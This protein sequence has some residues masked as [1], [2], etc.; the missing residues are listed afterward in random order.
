MHVFVTGGT[1]FIG[2]HSVA[3][4][5]GAGHKVRLFARNGNAVLPAL[6][7]LGIQP[8][9][10]EVVGVLTQ[11]V[12]RFVPWHIPAEYGAIYTC[13]CNPKLDGSAVSAPSRSVE[14]SM[15]DTVRW[16]HETGKLSRRYAG[17]AAGVVA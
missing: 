10:V 3:A 15:T 2:S 11:A 12:Q 4:L 9:D 17:K 8:G 16:L 5:R 1:G 13:L 7:P 6:G 14:E